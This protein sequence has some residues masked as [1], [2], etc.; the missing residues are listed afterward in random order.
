MIVSGDNSAAPEVESILITPVDHSL[1]PDNPTPIIDLT[2]DDN[3][4]HDRVVW[5][6][7]RDSAMTSFFITL[8][9]WVEGCEEEDVMHQRQCIRRNPPLKAVNVL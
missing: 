6:L 3:D 1:V 8:N 4:D 2:G 7:T 9:D 5:D